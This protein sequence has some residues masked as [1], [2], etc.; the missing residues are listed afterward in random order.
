MKYIV[1]REKFRRERFK[2]LE[3]GSLMGKAILRSGLVGVTSREQVRGWYD[4]KMRFRN[5][6]IYTGRG[7]GMNN[8]FGISRLKVLEM[9]RNGQLMGC[10]KGSW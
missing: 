2:K 1:K 8:F 5:R 9:S 6:C 10:R 3:V 7:R 4:Y